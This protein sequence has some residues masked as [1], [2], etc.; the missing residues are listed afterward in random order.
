M[1]QPKTGQRCNCKPGKQRDNCVNCEGTG[2]IIDHRDVR[3]KKLQNP[4]EPVCDL[5]QALVDAGQELDHHESDLYVLATDEAA[6]LVRLSRAKFS[7][8][9]S[10]RD[11]E[12]W[13]EV[14]FE[15]RP[16]W[17]R[18]TE[19]AAAAAP[20][21]PVIEPVV[22]PKDELCSDCG[23]KGWEIYNEGDEF[24]LGEVQR[25][26]T[27]KVFDTDFAAACAAEEAGYVLEVREW[28]P[29]SVEALPKVQG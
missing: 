28:G 1:F 6:E 24:L 21:K 26:D 14:P 20:T 18:V 27:C 2:W 9:R 4:P 13:I 16:Y 19:R 5:Y 22:E 15:W 8:F 10:E 29:I 3:E 7:T 23:G 25:C 12:L 11:G 17:D